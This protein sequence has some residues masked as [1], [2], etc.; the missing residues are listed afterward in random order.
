MFVLTLIRSEFFFLDVASTVF[1][2][3]LSPRTETHQETHIGLL[4]YRAAF[5]YHT[6]VC[7]RFS[8]SYRQS[9]LEHLITQLQFPPP[10]P[11][12]DHLIEPYQLSILCCCP[13]LAHPPSPFDIGLV[14]AAM[15]TLASGILGR[16]KR[17]DGRP[18]KG[19]EL[20]AG[21]VADFVILYLRIERGKSE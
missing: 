19:G 3:T 10:L 20:G 14:A 11:I 1:K 18:M 4:S 12:P 15:R 17:G 9:I 6:H 2:I 13:K 16:R 5:I 7:E 8:V 21:I